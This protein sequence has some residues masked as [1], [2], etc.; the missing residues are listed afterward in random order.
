MAD[1][2]ERL[3]EQGASQPAE[4]CGTASRVFMTCRRTILDWMREPS[5]SECRWWDIAGADC[6]DRV[7]EDEGSEGTS[8]D[9]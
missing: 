7:E 4:R 2:L 9:S 1:Y 5:V 6:P 8:E 3:K